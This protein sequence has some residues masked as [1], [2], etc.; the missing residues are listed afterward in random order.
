MAYRG[1]LF[2]AGALTILL[3]ACQPA[4]AAPDRPA[5]EP[6]GEPTAKP[7]NAPGAAA[8]ATPGGQAAPAKPAQA[9][10]PSAPVA[11]AKPAVQPA[12]ARQSTDGVP[13][14]SLQALP[15][16]FR[17]PLFL[18]HAG[19]GSGR[20]FVVEKGGTIR[21]VKQDRLL[22][23]PFIDLSS[24]VRSSGSEQ[25][26]LGLAFHPRYA[27]NG[28]FFVG[29]TDSAGR[30]TVERYQVSDDPDRADPSSGVIL[31]ALDDPAPNHNGGMVL[32]GPDGKLW[33]GTGDGGASG[34]RYQNGQ[35]KQ[36][37]L[38]KMLRLDVDAGEPYAVPADNPYANNPEYRGE[39]WAMGMRNPWRYSFD[40]ANG[41]L[42]IADV[43][44]NAYEEINWVAGGSPGGLNFGWP[45]VEGTHC[46]P[47]SARCDPSPYV[48]PVAVYGR[49]GGC[50]VTGGYVYRG[51]AYPSL[52]GLYF[53]GDF[54]SGRIWSVDRPDGAT[55]RTTEQV[56]ES[57]QISSFGEDEA[58][59]LYVTTFTGG[60]GG[61]NGGHQIF[62][63]AAQ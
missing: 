4:S 42:W 18:T 63:V 48:Q 36:T 40:R 14:I 27:E 13:K 19:D 37:L 39:I 24:K 30:N 12:P 57:F 55:W 54:C 56:K 50:S 31:L 7:A 60:S 59:E 29:Y 32:F 33:V 46:F 26:L 62:R 10:Q 35:N 20:M 43:G 61:G 23:T 6:S 9:S 11:A 16:G 47:A 2:L 1:R 52:Q 41:D 45:I 58:G 49:D 5:A 53:F 25:G 3:L 51:A 44:Q 22:P 28:R 34:D 8:P 38:G 21:I 15:L 17:Q